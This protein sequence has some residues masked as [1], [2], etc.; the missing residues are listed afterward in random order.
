[1]YCGELRVFCSL[2]LNHRH[3]P[4]HRSHRRHLL[5]HSCIRH[6]HPLLGLE[7]VNF[8]QFFK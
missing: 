2:L 1:M 6:H 5:P 8:L 7:R 3:L 4:P